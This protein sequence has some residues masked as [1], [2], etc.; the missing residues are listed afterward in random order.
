MSWRE[1]GR[2]QNCVKARQVGRARLRKRA[3]NIIHAGSG[4]MASESLS[5]RFLTLVTKHVCVRQSS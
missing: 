5:Q 4:G 1:P 3:A 2:S